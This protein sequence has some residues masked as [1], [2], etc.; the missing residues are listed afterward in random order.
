MGWDTNLGCHS[1][2]AAPAQSP[3]P[4]K[5]QV[6]PGADPAGPGTA[7]LWGACSVLG[8]RGQ[9]LLG[10]EAEATAPSGLPAQLRVF[11]VCAPMLLSWSKDSGFPLNCVKPPQQQGWPG[12]PLVLP[13]ICGGVRL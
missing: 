8:E 9:S 7:G 2:S 3:V 4:S 1:P 10:A 11:I 12:T 6:P 5:Q 13:W